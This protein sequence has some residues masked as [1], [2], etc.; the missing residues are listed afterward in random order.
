MKMQDLVY[1]QFQK[2][3]MEN[4]DW[5]LYDYMTTSASTTQTLKFFQNS[6]SV[7]KTRSNMP[8]AGQLPD[9]QAFLVTGIEC[10]VYN[11][12]GASFETTIGGTDVIYP[13][14]SM[15]AKSHMDINIAPKTMFESH[16]RSFYSQVDQIAVASATDQSAAG[17]NTAFF[18]RSY[19]FQVPLLILPQ[20]HFELNMTLTTPAEG[21]GYTAANTVIM[22]QLKGLLRRNSN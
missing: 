12:D 14:N 20:R 1:Q 6:S 8:I 7:G 15:L 9:P 10:I 18:K 4:V 16:M 17:I 11:L 22:W 3:G 2:E 13:I 19:K 5:C 21:G